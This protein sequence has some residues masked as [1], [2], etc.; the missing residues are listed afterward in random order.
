LAAQE[1]RGRAYVYTAILDPAE[2]TARRMRHLLDAGDDRTAV[3]ARF[4]G[5]LSDDDE[6]LLLEMLGAVDRDPQP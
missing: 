5:T 3:L 1:R 2:V 6:Q 4:V